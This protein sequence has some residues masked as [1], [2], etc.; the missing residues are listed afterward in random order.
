MRAADIVQSVFAGLPPANPANAA[1]PRAI[2]CDSGLRTAANPC[3]SGARLTAI[4]SHS[5]AFAKP[6]T[7]AIAGDSQDSQLAQG[8]GP[9]TLAEAPRLTARQRLLAWGWPA[10]LAAETAARIEARRA[11]DP[12]RTC[13]ECSSY[14]PGVHRCAR[15]RAA[16]LPGPDVGRDLAALPQHCPGFTPT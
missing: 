1:N 15:H 12:R 14:R 8:S 6:E 7:R 3:E 4:R 13:A 5:Q 10:D 11:D 9:K 16:A 2:A